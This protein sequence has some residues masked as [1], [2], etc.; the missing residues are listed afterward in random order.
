MSPNRADASAAQPVPPGP[1]MSPNRADASAAQPVPPAPQASPNRADASAAQAGPRTLYRRTLPE[2]LIAF[3]SSEGRSIFREALAA[4]TM[5]GYFALAEQFHTQGEP[6]FCGLGTLV[7]VLNALAIDPGRTWKGSWRWFA[8]DM[9]DCCRPLDEI[10]SRGITLAEFVC[11]ARCN[12]AKAEPQRPDDS[13]LEAFRR[14]VRESASGPDDSHVV[15]AYDRAELGQ[16]GAGHFSPIGGYHEARD[17]ALLLDVARFKY[18]PHWVPLPRLWQAMR[19]LD[20]T[21]GKSRGFVRLA[22]GATLP[23]LCNLPVSESASSVAMFAVRCVLDEGNAISALDVDPAA[24]AALTTP[25]PLPEGEAHVRA[26]A[27]LLDQLRATPLF[28]RIAPRVAAP[29]WPELVTLLAYAA[30]YQLVRELHE[31]AALV[32]AR[33]SRELPAALQVEIASVCAQLQTLTN[34]C[35]TG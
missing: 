32:L 25:R 12:G 10:K 11:L 14:T 33:D 20:P 1:P 24:V 35:R 13:S 2:E 4:G 7:I 29:I 31:G 34:Y 26:R 27:L 18:P 17:L 28:A 8:E 19:P 16:T 5:E 15:V 6:S 9:L 21:T 3:S 30:P 22:R 23:S